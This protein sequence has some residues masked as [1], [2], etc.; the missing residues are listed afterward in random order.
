VIKFAGN[1]ET[2]QIVHSN[3]QNYVCKIE[4]KEE[5]VK[6]LIHCAAL[7]DRTDEM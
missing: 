1:T 3:K 2:Q 5:V 7:I 6:L 4:K